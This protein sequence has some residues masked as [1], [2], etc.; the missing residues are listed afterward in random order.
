MNY[1]KIHLTY[2]ARERN[3]DGTSDEEKGEEEDE[4]RARAL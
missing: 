2:H 4:D 1:V 3:E